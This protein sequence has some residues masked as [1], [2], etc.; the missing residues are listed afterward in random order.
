MDYW[1]P[2]AALDQASLRN[3]FDQCG[4]QHSKWYVYSSPLLSGLLTDIGFSVWASYLYYSSPRYLAAFLVNLASSV[5]AIILATV[6]RIY[7]RRQNDKLDRG[8]DTGGKGPTPAQIAAG[9]RYVI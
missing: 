4:L 5:L 9:F 8:L 2:V 3:R 1:Q 6:T 7:L